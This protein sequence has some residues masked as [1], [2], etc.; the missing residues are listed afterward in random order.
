MKKVGVLVLLFIFLFSL[1]FVF[2][3]NC[4]ISS[5]CSTNQTC[6][7][8][9]CV[10]SSTSTT[11][12]SSTL[13]ANLSQLEKGYSCLDTK[14][15]GKCSTLSVS[16]ISF[17]LLSN[18]SS[19]LTSQC[20]DALMTKKS[21]NNCWPSASC[22][23]KDTALA[24]LAL[25]NLGEDTSAYES[26]LLSKNR[27][28]TDI[29]WYLEEDS[30]NN[31]QCKITYSGNDNTINIGDN[32][33]IDSDAGSCLTRAQSN[34]WLQ[35][36][37]SCYDKEFAV[38]C[39]QNFI[40]TLL[41]KHESSPTI[42]VSSDTKS[43]PAL[44][45]VTLNIKAKCFGLSSCDYEGSLWATLA[46]LKTDNDIQPFIPYIVALGDVNKKYLP[47]S[48][49]YMATNYPDYATRL[50][51]E[52][53]T[54]NNWEADSS[55]YGKYYDTA[56]GLLALRDSVASQVNQAKLWLGYSQ[57][58]AS[59]CWKSQNELRDTAIILWAI[60]SRTG[61]IVSTATTTCAEANFFCIPQ[62]ECLASDRL[63][64]YYCPGINPV[65]CKN[66]NI[67]TCKEYSGQ[68]CTQG[69][70]CSGSER[71][72]SDTN[73]CCLAE[74]IV[75]E[76]T[77]NEC[78]NNN[79]FCKDSCAV[80]QETISYACSGGQTCC[81]PKTPSPS[82][83]WLWILIGILV[84]L[85]IIA[86]LFRDKIRLWWFNFRN[87][88]KKDNSKPGPGGPGMPPQRPGFPPLRPM[89]GR[90]MAQGRPMLQRPMPTQSRPQRKEDDT[91]K[92][93]RE[94]SK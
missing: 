67:K 29:I 73:Y 31:T 22:T 49:I 76:E 11:A 18:P 69:K 57:D 40:S 72:S 63:P 42:Y 24:V 68:E 75:P 87:K 21:S 78:E 9:T 81:K 16:E 27:T 90:P 59:G 17:I 58:S 12:T 6:S 92:K 64:N 3:Q 82:Y 26:W 19:D 51:Q 8:S 71:K 35:V 88:V 50:I 86:F 94:M 37:S 91:F 46:L 36:S 44:G 39:N 32:K 14:A 56:L 5:D 85:A 43:A 93:L 61:P 7:N 25:D 34:F 55:Q 77:G 84:V 89:P 23:I 33:K 30:L 13:E 83:L 70:V 47:N 45:T 38:S 74:C 4:T 66:E 15:K 60:T 52:Q 79:Y 1:T 20:K 54:G 62:Q 48:F 65:C 41:Y 28:P 2:A 53:R 10:T 80:N